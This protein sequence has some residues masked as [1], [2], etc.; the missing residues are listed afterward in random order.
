MLNNL[1][2]IEPEIQF[3]YM[4]Q[5][6]LTSKPFIGLLPPTLDAELYKVFCL[7]HSL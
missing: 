3:N 7:E 6:Q 2:L 5:L 1:E 4:A